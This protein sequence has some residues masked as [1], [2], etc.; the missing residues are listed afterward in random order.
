MEKVFE[1]LSII[2]ETLTNDKGRVMC[3]KELDVL[4]QAITELKEIKE[5]ESSEAI[6]YIN[7]LIKENDNDIKNQTNT[8]FDRDTQAKWVKYLEHK[9]TMLST[10]EQYILKTQEFEKVSAIFK[11]KPFNM[12]YFVDEIRADI[13][14]RSYADYKMWLISKGGRTINDLLTEDE[15]ETLMRW[16]NEQ[17][18]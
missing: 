6:T 13:Y 10:I 1:A 4:M 17:N 18:I 14:K 2:I 7:A 9:S 12:I 3:R 8:G 5:A 16:Q 15:F 11:T